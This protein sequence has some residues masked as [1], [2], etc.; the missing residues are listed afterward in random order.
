M[1]ILGSSW[2]SLA[3]GLVLWA[4]F[5]EM[6]LIAKKFEV[7]FGRHSRWEA[8]ALAPSGLALY[9]LLA[10]VGLG[11][12]NQAAAREAAYW[13][14]FVSGLLCAWS[15]RRFWLLLRSLESKEP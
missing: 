5:L 7:V 9:S 1:S 13:I 3:G 15:A 8:M 12:L 10:V 11:G 6:A 4:A 14:L 2:I